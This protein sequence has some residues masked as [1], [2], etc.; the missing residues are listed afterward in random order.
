MK[1]NLLHL[2]LFILWLSYWNFFNPWI[3]LNCS[4]IINLIVN[5]SGAIVGLGLVFISI[6]L[7]DKKDKRIKFLEGIVK[8]KE[9]DVSDLAN[10]NEELRVMIKSLQDRYLLLSQEIGEKK[11]EVNTYR[12]A[13]NAAESVADQTEKEL[14]S[15][16]KKVSSLSGN[17][18]KLRKNCR[19]KNDQIYKLVKQQAHQSIK[20]NRLIKGLNEISARCELKDLEISQLRTSINAF[21]R[22]YN[23]TKDSI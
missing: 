5:M 9:I 2:G 19:I 20:F 6:V 3:T 23:E 12:L 1:K 22:F 17:I 8:L 15:Y 16:K 14:K 13:C 18:G 21:K 7:T 4:P 10:D 11:K